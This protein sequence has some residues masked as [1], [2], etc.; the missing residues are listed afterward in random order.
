M[1]LVRGRKS[2]GDDWP[3]WHIRLT[4]AGQTKTLSEWTALS[5]IRRTTVYQRIR[6]GDFPL[7]A[8]TTFDKRGNRLSL[9]A[10]RFP[11]RDV[12]FN[13]DGTVTLD[14]LSRETLESLH[15]A[16]FRDGGP[17]RFADT[18][19]EFAERDQ[20]AL[21]GIKTEVEDA[22]GRLKEAGIVAVPLRLPSSRD[23]NLLV[24]IFLRRQSRL[25]TQQ[26]RPAGVLPLRTPQHVQ[27]RPQEP[28][29]PDRT[30]SGGIGLPD[31]LPA[32]G[33]C[34]AAAEAG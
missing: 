25:S 8:L 14:A 7:Q 17:T 19:A 16:V 13:M 29:P 12:G 18:I 20:V 1:Y 21:L 32:D 26:P 33:S 2:R 3:G 23:H 31:G 11:W 24:E 28:S 6:R 15:D 34:E 9:I 27:E 5:R 10:P 22:I 4:L 30:E